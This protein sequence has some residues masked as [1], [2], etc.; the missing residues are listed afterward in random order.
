VSHR[1]LLFVVNFGDCTAF[2]AFDV[3]RDQ[4]SCRMA[5]RPKRLILF[6]Y[7]VELQKGFLRN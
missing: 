3:D 1:A 2:Q 6:R 5:N 7:S 4:S